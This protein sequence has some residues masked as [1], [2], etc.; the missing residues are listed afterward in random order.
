MFGASGVIFIW[1]GDD[2]CVFITTG[3]E[4]DDGEEALK[5][6]Q[7]IISINLRIY[8]IYNSIFKEFTFLKKKKTPLLFVLETS[9]KEK[10]IPYTKYKCDSKQ[11]SG[12]AHFHRESQDWVSEL[13]FYT[14]LINDP[15]SESD[16]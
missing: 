8:K 16:M 15:L 13:L 7:Y 3:T 6:L 5:L 10:A 9:D 14:E 4:L 2:K 11:N 1:G 12:H